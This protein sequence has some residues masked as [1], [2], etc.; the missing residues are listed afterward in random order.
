MVLSSRRKGSKNS[1]K[2]QAIVKDLATYQPDQIILFGSQAHGK[3]DFYSDVDLV[4][5]KDTDVNF[6]DRGVEARRLIR[7]N[8]LPVDIFVYTH[9]EWQALREWESPFYEA[10]MNTGRVIYEKR[11]R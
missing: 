7:P 6:L 10:V 4:V 2:I 5:L 1:R 11:K 3:S 9:Q 8:L